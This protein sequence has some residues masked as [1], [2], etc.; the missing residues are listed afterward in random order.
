MGWKSIKA[1]KEGG[2]GLAG[3]ENEDNAD[4]AISLTHR[5]RERGQ[6]GRVREVD[7]ER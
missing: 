6:W 1:E 7:R 4:T 5:G 2:G 3:G